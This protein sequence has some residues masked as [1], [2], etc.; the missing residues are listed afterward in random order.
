MGGSHNYSVHMHEEKHHH[1]PLEEG[2][3]T[4]WEINQKS[5]LLSGLELI[6]IDLCFLIVFCLFVV[7]AFLSYTDPDRT[8]WSK[9]TLAWRSNTNTRS[10]SSLCWHLSTW[11]ITNVLTGLTSSQSEGA[12][13]QKPCVRFPAQSRQLCLPEEAPTHITLP[14]LSNS[15]HQ[16]S[17]GAVT[18][19]KSV[20][21]LDE[22]HW[23]RPALQSSI[24]VLMC[25]RAAGRSSAEAMLEQ[26]EEDDLLESW[27]RSSV[28]NS[29]DQCFCMLWLSPAL[30]IPP[31]SEWSLEEWRNL[32]LLAPLY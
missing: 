8:S 26:A 23:C 16:Q 21:E 32:A 18:R 28:S 9:R 3:E 29:V 13:Q 10:L 31:N 30:L 12:R 1:R 7:F 20:P 14:E 19:L 15:L 5:M 24:R 2:W 22:Q 27:E 25:W 4:C 6:L 17:N 11:D